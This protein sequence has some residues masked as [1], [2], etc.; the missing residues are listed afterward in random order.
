MY[1]MSNISQ[2]IDTFHDNDDALKKHTDLFMI[3]VIV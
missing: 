1:S 3:T 2:K